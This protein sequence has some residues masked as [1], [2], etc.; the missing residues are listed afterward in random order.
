MPSCG[1][2]P[3]AVYVPM[4]GFHLADIELERLG[5]R[6]RKG[7]IDTFDSYGYRALLQRIPRQHD[8][9]VYAPAFPRDLEQP[10]AGSIAVTPADRLIV[11]EGNYLLDDADPWP[12]GRQLLDEVWYV[13]APVDERRRRLEARHIE[14][15]KS[16]EQAHAWVRDVDEP[17]AARIQSTRHG[18]DWSGGNSAPPAGC[19]QHHAGLDQFLVQARFGLILGAPRHHVERHHTEFDTRPLVFPRRFP[20]AE[21]M[22]EWRLLT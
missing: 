19:G 9:T 17:N 5:R 1:E 12:T 4:D 15:G 3:A 2:T 16:P 14:F 21:M 20:A 11:T 10:I 22:T 18:A 8:E 6:D 7:V 13:D